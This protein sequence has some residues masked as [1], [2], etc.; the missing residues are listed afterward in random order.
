MA[1]A[2]R[3]KAPAAVSAGR[4]RRSVVVQARSG[5]GE[6][7]AVVAAAALV[8]APANAGVVLQKQELKKVFQDDGSAPAPVK[9]SEPFKW[10]PPTFSAPSTSADKP[11]A[12]AAPK[13]EKKAESSSEGPSLD[14]RSVALPGALLVTVGGFFAATKVDPSFGEWLQTTADRDLNNY[15]GFESTLK[16]EGGVVYPKAGTKKVKAASGTKKGKK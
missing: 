9:Q 10:T 11:A 16:A 14:P 8:A 1:V 6:V 5:F 3:C 15:V 4:S 12:A 7:A 13:A 2:A